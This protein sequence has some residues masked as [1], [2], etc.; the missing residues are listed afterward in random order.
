MVDL[1]DNHFG[2]WTGITLLV[3][4]TISTPA[5][6]AQMVDTSPILK[7]SSQFL[8][9]NLLP[10]LERS[11][12]LLMMTKNSS[13]TNRTSY[14][15]SATCPNKLS[16]VLYAIDFASERLSQMFL[17]L[18]QCN[19]SLNPANTNVILNKFQI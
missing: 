19:F 9:G 1:K 3:I 17:E 10:D 4:W 14:L 6:A 7:S 8:I 16:S 13:V 15:S 11:R 5:A 12:S 2:A 18:Y